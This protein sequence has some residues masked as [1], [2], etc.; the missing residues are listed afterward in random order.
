VL[1]FKGESADSEDGRKHGV[2]S[3]CGLDFRSNVFLYAGTFLMPTLVYSVFVMVVH[4]TP[5]TKEHRTWLN[6]LIVITIPITAFIFSKTVL[7]LRRIGNINS[8][9]ALLILTIIITFVFLFFL[10]RTIFI[11]AGK[12]AAVWRK[13]QLAWKIPVSI[14]LPL[15]GLLV[16]NGV[17]FDFFVLDSENDSGVF[18]NFNSFWFYGIAVL[19]GILICLPGL[20]NKIYRLFL[21]AG[22]SIT[23]AY[24]FY[25]FLVFLPFLPFSIVAIIAFGTGFLMLTPLLLLGVHANELVKDY[26]RLI[27]SLPKKLVI[28][29]LLSGFLV[30]PVIITAAYLRDRSVL[31]KTLAYLYSPDYSN[32]S[33]KRGYGIGRN[34]LKRTLNVIKSHTNEN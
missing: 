23:F 25:F 21:F 9:H 22:R 12:K 13:Y 4:L 31:N 24:T 1:P 32:L 6:F 34:S 28:G 26:K 19:N 15:L 11:V 16:N 33:G 14:L 27:L 10:I 3:N 5:E 2:L 30:I 29:V 8:I 17:L 7:S 20:E 18:G